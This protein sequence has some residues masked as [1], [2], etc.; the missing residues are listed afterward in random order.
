MDFILGLPRTQR[1]NDSI[2][3]MVD[4][5]TKMAHCIP[6]SKTNDATNIVNLFFNEVVKLHGLP[7][8]IVS[9]RDVR[10]TSHF[11]KTLWK[12]L[13]TKL[14]FSSSYHPQSD[15][16]TEV[17]NRSLGNMLRSLVGGNPKQW[18]KVLAQ[19]EFSY[20][21]SPNRSTGMSPFKILYGMHPRRVYELRDLGYL[22]KRSA[23]GEDFAAR[24]IELWE[25][26][27]A[28]LQKSNANYKARIDSKRRENNFEIGDLVLAHLRKERFPKGEYH[29]LKMK[30]IGPCKILRKFSGN[31]NRDWHITYF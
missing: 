20:N 17:V 6:C 8:S 18:D 23:Y 1:G 15:G 30:K 28:R 22:E 26:V 4:R 19:T 24:I 27:K 31:A 16:Q 13:G 10:F 9:D 2:F 14:N 5:F 21:D 12:K 7:R 29:K 25:E 3:I 11:W